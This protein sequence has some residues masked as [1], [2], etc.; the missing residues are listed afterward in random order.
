MEGIHDEETV[1]KWTVIIIPA[2]F[3]G[4]K[5]TVRLLHRIAINFR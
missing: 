3:T 4:D 5:K 2:V 1:R